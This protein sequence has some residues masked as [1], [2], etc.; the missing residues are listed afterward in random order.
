MLEISGKFPERARVSLRNFPEKACEENN[1]ICKKWDCKNFKWLRIIRSGNGCRSRSQG[2]DRSRRSKKSLHSKLKTLRFFHWCHREEHWGTWVREAALL[3]GEYE[4]LCRATHRRTGIAITQLKDCEWWN[5]AE[6]HLYIF[7]VCRA[8]GI[9]ESFLR[10]GNQRGDS[11]DD[12]SLTTELV[13]V[14]WS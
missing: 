7:N 3:E 14:G 8:L 4:F 2:E 11:S 12:L 13:G 6:R 5:M 1:S 9:H 10:K